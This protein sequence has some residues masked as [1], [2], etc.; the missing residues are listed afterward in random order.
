MKNLRDGPGRLLGI[1][2]ISGLRRRWRWPIKWA[3][4]G[5]AVFFVCYPDP[6]LFWRHVSRWR[7]PDAL[8]QPDSP[9]KVCVSV[10]FP[11]R[12]SRPI[13]TA[14][15]SPLLVIAPVGPV[16]PITI[17]G[18]PPMSEPPIMTGPMSLPARISA[19]AK[20]APPITSRPTV[21]RSI[22]PTAKICPSW[23]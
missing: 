11:P 7:N 1:R 2:A 8:I 6:R 23:K 10:R 14:P 16:L 20:P 4:L 12:R 18:E 5:V 19:E 9:R 3:I 22:L 15:M 17:S 21:T 13:F